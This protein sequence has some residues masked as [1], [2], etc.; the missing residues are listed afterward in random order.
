MALNPIFWL[1]RWGTTPAVMP[2]FFVASIL[3]MIPKTWEF[4]A[5]L[6]IHRKDISTLNKGHW[7]IIRMI[8]FFN[9]ISILICWLIN[10]LCHLIADIFNGD[11]FDFDGETYT[12]RSTGESVGG[13]RAFPLRSA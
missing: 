5:S 2:V 13:L 8:P 4:V 9:Y 12:Y 11:M 7:F 3:L 6:W 1:A 10:I